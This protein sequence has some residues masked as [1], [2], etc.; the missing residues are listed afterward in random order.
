MGGSMSSVVISGDTSG[1]ITL[2]ASA[3]AGTNT[4]TLPAQTGT[5]TV[6]GPAFRAVA[7]ATQ[8]CTINTTTKCTS[9]NSVIYDTNSC[10]SA[11]NNRFTPTV[12]GYYDVN[13]GMAWG[14]GFTTNVDIIYL[15]IVKNGN[16]TYTSTSSMVEYT[17]VFSQYPSNTLSGLVYC[18][19]TT[20]YIEIYLEA[21]GVSGTRPTTNDTRY[22]WLSIAMVRGA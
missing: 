6:G 11:A 2:S 9:Y 17:S 10:W 18:N 22:C 16:Y 1:A 4:I 21:G 8:T 5:V 3:V 20:D 19:G 12:A 7:N 14:T 15:Y 13:A